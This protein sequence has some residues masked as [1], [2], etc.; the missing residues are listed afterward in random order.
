MVYSVVLFHLIISLLYLI[1][2]LKSKK[3][4]GFWRLVIVFTIPIFG[5]IYIAFVE[6]MDKYKKDLQYEVDFDGEIDDK[7]QLINK[8]DIDK[9]LNIIPMEE[10][11]ILNKSSIK[12]VMVVD[13]IKKD[14]L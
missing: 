2:W 5:L 14:I 9:D 6:Y 3:E 1:Y 4:L 13:M 11:L 12:R 7:L 10:A 8:V